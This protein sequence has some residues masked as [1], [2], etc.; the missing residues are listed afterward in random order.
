MV[1]DERSMAIAIMTPGPFRR[2]QGQLFVLA[3]EMVNFINSFKN[4]DSRPVNHQDRERKAQEL[5]RKLQEIC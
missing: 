2:L 5:L 4:D 1:I 3:P